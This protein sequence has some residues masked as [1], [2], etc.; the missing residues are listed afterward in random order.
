MSELVQPE[1]IFTHESDLDGFV[2]GCLLQ[3][4]AKILFKVDVPV[5]P[6]SSSPWANLKRFPKRAWVCDLSF[7]PKLDR[8][9]WAIVDHHTTD[10]KPEAATL[11]HDLN[12]SAAK[13]C[14]NLL[15][16]NNGGNETLEKL[17]HLTN[18]A[19]LYLCDEPDFNLASDYARLVKTYHFRSLYRLIGTDLESLVGH[20]LLELMKL[21]RQ[22]E[23]PI[24]FAWSKEHVTEITSEVAY[25]A[26]AIGD[27][28]FIV[29]QLLELEELPFKVLVTF[30]KKPS[31]PVTASIRSQNGEALTLAK[32]LQGGGHPNA[33]GTTLPRSVT[34]FEGAA[35]YLKQV[36]TPPT[37]VATAASGVGTEALFD[38]AGF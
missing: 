10:H 27:T 36:L 20:P 9:G 33:A 37:P 17:V 3:R 30:F 4:L 16:K 14:Y 11:V 38:S 13:L 12:H 7:D 23:D 28:N 25:V 34:T 5:E 15:V 1:I 31:G 24:G 35:A 26:T 22:V 6:L 19:D 21:K 8:E 18:V 29:H 2:S 32:Q